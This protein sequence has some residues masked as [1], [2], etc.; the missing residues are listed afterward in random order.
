MG[1]LAEELILVD[2]MLDENSKDTLTDSLENKT[3]WFFKA[4]NNTSESKIKII[5]KTLGERALKLNFFD[6]IKKLI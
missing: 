2:E 6:I 5:K 1:I 4:L 3:N